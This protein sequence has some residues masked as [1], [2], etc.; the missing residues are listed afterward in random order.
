MLD[1]GKEKNSMIKKLIAWKGKTWNIWNHYNYVMA[2]VRRMKIQ[3]II[4]MD[5]E[6]IKSW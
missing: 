5:S 6:I 1:A 3:K 4:V 2:V